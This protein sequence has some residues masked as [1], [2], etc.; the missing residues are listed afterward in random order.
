LSTRQRTAVGLALVAVLA[1]GLGAGYWLG[2]GNVGAGHGAAAATATAAPPVQGERRILYYRNPMGL[3][4]KSDTPKKDPMGMDY[5]PVYEG[6]EAAPAGGAGANVVK[7]SA[8]RVQKLGVRVATAEARVIDRVVRAVGRVE[9][10]ERRITTIAP[11]FEGWIERLHVNTTGQ[12]VTPGQPLFEVYSPELVAAQ[13]E[14]TIAMQ[15]V[16]S[17]KGGS[18]DVQASMQ[19]LAESTLA[20]L[21]NWDISEEQVRALAGSQAARRTLTFKAPAGGVVTEKKAVQGMRFMPGEMLYQIADLSSVWVLADVSEQDLAAVRPGTN[22]QLRVA[23]YPSRSF[24]ARVTFVYPT[25]NAETRTVPVRLEM[26][27]PGGLLKPAMFGQ[28]D[29]AVQTSQSGVTVPASSVIDSGTRQIVLVQQDIGRF[30]PREVKL[31]QAGRDFVEVLEGVRAGESVVV[32]ANFL[33]DAE[34]NLKAALGGLGHS[35]HGAAPA[36]RASP[37]AGQAAAA[38]HRAQGTVE[39]VDAAKKRVT[40]AH[41]PVPSLQWPAMTME[42]A[43]ANTALLDGVVAGQAVEVEFVERQP[44]EWLIVKLA[45][46]GASAAPVAPTSAGGQGRPGS[47]AGH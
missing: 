24:A 32:S 35:A 16:A 44:G 2:R 14:Y 41:G 28:V 31:G 7:I 8:D 38:A 29:F 21:K 40:L 15:G 33:I 45:R 11:K 25:L 46:R 36:A 12:S 47:H 20:R 3:P 23:S 30:E 27:N 1:A 19:R 17:V 42:F 4:D 6:E 34:S 22:A 18:D 39:G 26:P 10:D 13:R 37:A 9:V 5:I 43:V